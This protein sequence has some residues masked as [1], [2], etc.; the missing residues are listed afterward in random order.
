MNALT[1][2][3]PCTNDVTVK[4]RIV[5][6]ELVV[7]LT[8]TCRNEGGKLNGNI[9]HRCQVSATKNAD[10]VQTTASNCQVT[11]AA[12]SCLSILS[13]SIREC[14]GYK[15]SYLEFLMVYMEHKLKTDLFS[16]LTIVKLGDK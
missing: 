13:P 8:N 1:H 6:D 15:T 3:T 12:N 11:H 14:N 9:A 16:Y 10:V 4:Q 7:K 5:V 2:C